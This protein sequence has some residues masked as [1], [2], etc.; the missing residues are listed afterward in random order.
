MVGYLRTAILEQIFIFW[1]FLNSVE[2]RFHD[3]PKCQIF[4][5]E[6]PTSPRSGYRPRANLA[7]KFLHPQLC[8]RNSRSG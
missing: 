5:G 4:F 2:R 6:E 7:Q 3:L 8:R 1:L